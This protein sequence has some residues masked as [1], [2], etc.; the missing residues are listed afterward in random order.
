[1]KSTSHLRRRRNRE[2]IVGKKGRSEAAERERERRR[3]GEYP[4]MTRRRAKAEGQIR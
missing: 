1:M 4:M 2:M 3:I